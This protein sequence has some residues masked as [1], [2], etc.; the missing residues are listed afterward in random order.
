MAEKNNPLREVSILV[1]SS[2]MRKDLTEQIT[3]KMQLENKILELEA[4][5]QSFRDNAKAEGTIPMQTD[6]KEKESNGRNNSQREFDDIESLIEFC[7]VNDKES[8]K[9]I[10]AK[11]FGALQGNNFEWTDKFDE[12]GR[13]LIGR[14]LDRANQ[15]HRRKIRG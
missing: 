4:E 11:T 12:N 2:K 10:K 3:E 15:D 8:Y 14:T 9:K 7:R 6:M 5:N 1:D 13:S